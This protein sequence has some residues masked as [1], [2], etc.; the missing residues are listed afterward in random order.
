MVGLCLERWQRLIVA[1]LGVLG[2]GRRYLPLDPDEPGERLAYMLGRRARRWC[3]CAGDSGAQSAGRAARVLDWTGGGAIDAALAAAGAAGRREAGLCDV[4]LG[5]DRPAEG[6]GDPAPRDRAAGVQHRLCRA[7]A[8]TVI[9]Q[10]STALFD[11]ATFEIWGALL[12]GARCASARP[13]GRARPRRARR[14]CCAGEQV[15]HAVPDHGAVQP[16][17]RSSIPPLFSGLEQVL[18]GGEAV[19]PRR[20]RGRCSA[21]ARR[22][23]CCTSTARPRPRRSP[24]VTL[25]E[26]G[27]EPTRAPCR[28]GGRSPTRTSYVLD[29]AAAR[30]R[31]GWPASCTS[32]ATAWRAAIAAARS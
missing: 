9:A 21:R 25:V 2:R 32:A 29:A 15:E 12:N 19:D 24:A 5:L 27:A 31:S 13:R 10:A 4:H 16:M 28:S 18:F 30:C 8:A 22:A 23:G 1:M 17:W 7:A 11:A 26:R 3:W 14:H 6:G 20:G